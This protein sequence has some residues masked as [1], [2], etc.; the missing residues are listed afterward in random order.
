MYTRD[1]GPASVPESYSGNLFSEERE[2]PVHNEPKEE[3]ESCGVFGGLRSFWGN[4][5]N[6]KNLSVFKNG[7]G[8]EELLIIGIAAFL[9]FSKDGDKECA[10]ILL[11]TLFLS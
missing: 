10:I 3:S 6:L 1:F 8:T 11:L 2:A 9:F 4:S 7:F 5:F